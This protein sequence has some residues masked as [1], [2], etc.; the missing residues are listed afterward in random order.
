MDLAVVRTSSR[1]LARV[2]AQIP[3][4]HSLV[5]WVYIQCDS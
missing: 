3:E 1:T 4:V 5:P 2:A